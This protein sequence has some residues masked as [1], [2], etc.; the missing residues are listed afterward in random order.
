[1]ELD[2]RAFARR[3]HFEVLPAFRRYG[4]GPFN[5]RINHLIIMSRVVM[6]KQKFPNPCVQRE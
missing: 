3:F 6:K 1:V 5:H 2:F 4:T